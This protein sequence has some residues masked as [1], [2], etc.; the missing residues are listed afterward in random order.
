MNLFRIVFALLIVSGTFIGGCTT[1]QP[2]FTNERKSR[3]EGIEL[4][5]RADYDNALGAFR[6]AVRQDPRDFRSQ[7]YLGV[8]YERMGNYQQAVQAYKS[9]LKVMRETPAGR[10]AVDYRQVV[11]NTLASTIAKHDDN[12]LEQ[13]LLAKQ[14]ASASTPDWQRS[15]D[16]FVLAKIARYRRD[17]DSA[18]TSYLK[19]AEMNRDDLWA[20]KEAGLYLL[21]MGMANKAYKPLKRAGELTSHDPELNAALRQLNIP[22][23]PALIQNGGSSAP[24][25]N[26]APLPSVPL[27]VGDTPVT[28]PDTL[29]VS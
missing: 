13:D 7:Y 6:N 26:P 5:N 19:A 16:Y 15:E 14:A 27:K 10:D 4:Y 25:T 24:L 2:V 22:Q 21:Q 23:S 9:A 20:Q 18:I 3:L 28:L 1:D 12:R 8:T 17:A 11:L 29:P